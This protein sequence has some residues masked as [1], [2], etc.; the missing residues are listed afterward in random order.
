MVF[1]SPVCIPMEFLLFGLCK[2]QCLGLP[3]VANKNEKVP[4][5][6]QRRIKKLTTVCLYKCGIVLRSVSVM[7]N[8]VCMRKGEIIWGTHEY[9]GG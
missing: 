8:A 5:M 7:F 6:N 2:E 4:D 3:S 1:M 9:A